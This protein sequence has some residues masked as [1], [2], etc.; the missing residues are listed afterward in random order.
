MAPTNSNSDLLNNSILNRNLLLRC[1][2]T[3]ICTKGTLKSA[4]KQLLKRGRPDRLQT[5]KLS[6]RNLGIRE[7][8]AAWQLYVVI[9]RRAG[10]V[11]RPEPSRWRH[12]RSVNIKT[13]RWAR[14]FAWPMPPSYAEPLSDHS[15]G[16]TIQIMSANQRFEFGLIFTQTIFAR[17]KW[18]PNTGTRRGTQRPTW[19][20]LEQTAHIQQFPTSGCTKEL[21]WQFW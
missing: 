9:T 6:F 5:Y 13:K 19:S 17:R 21:H 11:T 1:S 20:F 3:F 18:T 4:A 10:V 2:D 8:F 16:R 15:E 14:K 12:T 7:K